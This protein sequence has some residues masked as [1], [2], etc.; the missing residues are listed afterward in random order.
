MEKLV[1]KIKEQISDCTK[2]EG[3]EKEE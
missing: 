2:K 1:K 3:N